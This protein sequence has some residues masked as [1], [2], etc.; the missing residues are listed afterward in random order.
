MGLFRYIALFG[1]YFRLSVQSQLEY[2]LRIASWAVLIPL[3]FFSGILILK[4]LTLNFE[5]IGGWDF[6]QLVMLYGFSMLSNALFMTFFVATWNIETLVIRG[7]M[8]LFSIRPISVLFQVLFRSPNVLGLAEVIPATMIIAYAW[9]ELGLAVTDA[10]LWLVFV[11][12]IV[13]A[14]LLRAGIFLVLGSAAFWV[15]KSRPLV[16]GGMMLIDR[17]TYYPV[18]VYPAVIQWGM[19]LVLPL[20]FI[21]YYPVKYMLGYQN[22]SDVG[23]QMSYLAAPVLAGLITFLAGIAVFSKGYGRYESSGS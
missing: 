21:G 15:K 9:K 4:V 3:Q 20:A 17:T 22:L 23:E 8:D 13:A 14:T 18:S 11:A 7:E 5:D 1:L 2:P 10:H 12:F 19:T 6:N 16:S